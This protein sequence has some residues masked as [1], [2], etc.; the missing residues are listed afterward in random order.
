M[1]QQTSA[2]DGVN[3]LLHSSPRRG[4]STNHNHDQIVLFAFSQSFG[5]GIQ[6]L[7]GEI[8]GRE[9]MKNPRVVFIPAPSH[10]Q[11]DDSGCL[12]LVERH[13]ARRLVVALRPLHGMGP[14]ASGEAVEGIQAVDA[15]MVRRVVVVVVVDGSGMGAYP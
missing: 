2:D 13:K 14:E 15:R 4:C 8:T 3:T 11:A 5:R 7:L 10:R 12:F 1:L 6:E 9:S